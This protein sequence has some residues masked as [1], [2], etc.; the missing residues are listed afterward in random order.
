MLLNLV[1]NA[2]QALDGPGSVTVTIDAHNSMASVA[3]QDTGP[4]IPPET[5]PNIFRPFFTTKGHGTGLGLSLAKRIAEDHGGELNVT[6]KPGH[7]STFTL[8]LPFA[9]GTTV[10][11]SAD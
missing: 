1:L 9:R 11:A 3:V 5:L 8:L 4:G 2:I 6:S 10:S 7:G